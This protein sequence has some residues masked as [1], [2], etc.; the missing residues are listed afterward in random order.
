MF[1]VWCRYQE[2]PK[3]ALLPFARSLDPLGKSWD[4]PPRGIVTRDSTTGG[5]TGPFRAG[6]MLHSSRAET[7]G[8]LTAGSLRRSASVA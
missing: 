2:W 5:S 3:G 1:C 7:A 8:S 6:I 4:E